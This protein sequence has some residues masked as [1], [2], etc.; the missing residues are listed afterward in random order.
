MGIVYLGRDP[1]IGRLV[2]LKTIL[3]IGEDETEQR[4]FGERFL[5]EAQAAGILSHPNIVTIHDVGEDPSSQTAFI[6]MEYVEGKNLKQLLQ[7]K[8]AYTWE[9]VA[10]IIGQVAEA[11]D[12]AHRRGIVHRDVKPANIIITPEGGV[13]ITDFGIAKIEHSNLTTEGQFLGTPNY[14]SPEQVTG[15]AVDGRTDLFSLGVVLYELLTR[16][17]PFTADN[18]TS[19]SFKIVHEPFVPPETYAAMVPPEF[20]PMLQKV[21]SKDPAERY[22]RGNDLALALYE[23]KAREEERQM[24]RDLGNMVAEAENLG[25][26]GAMQGSV[27]PFPSPS[28]GLPPGRGAPIGAEG[29]MTVPIFPPAPP[30]PPVPRGPDSTAAHDASAP[31]WA[32]DEPAPEA[33]SEPVRTHGA[34]PKTPPPPVPPKASKPEEEARPTVI[35]PPSGVPGPAAQ[36]HDATGSRVGTGVRPAPPAHLPL[37]NRPTEVIMDAARLASQGAPPPRPP[38][39]APPTRPAAAPSTLPTPSKA[40]SVL[41]PSQ[42]LQLEMTETLAPLPPVPPPPRA[43]APKKK[44]GSSRF[45]LAVVGGTL[46]LAA[47]ILGALWTRKAV[48]ERNVQATEEAKAREVAERADLMAEGNRLVGAGS[49]AEA[50]AKYREIVR[51]DPSS[52]AARDAVAKTEVLL[53]D[54]EKVVSRAKEIESHLALARQADQARDDLKVIEET[55]AALF[56]EPENAE[57]KSLHEAAHAR[58]ASRGAAEQ[59]KLAEELKKKAKPTQAPLPSVAA[60]VAAPRLARETAPPVPTPATA[61]VGISFASPIPEGHVMVSLNDKFIFRKSFAFGKKSGGG[62]VD[63][64]AEVPSGRGSFKVWVIAPDR[65]IN[66]Y[67]ELPVSIPG[68]ETKTLRLDL[69]ATGN[70]TVSLR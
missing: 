70:L 32:L 39:P 61:K 7:E 29:P 54:K 15:D 52:A 62:Q 66:Q 14:M 5:R 11:L 44:E 19:I 43:E 35:L 1:V 68:G 57:G 60:P 38:A 6:A 9:R 3:A 55:E 28:D 2:A 48:N 20:S 40:S 46:L 30:V 36:R 50:L 23:F 63:G 33:K 65:S 37:E 17:K 22:Q 26:I 12:Y 53:A 64:S 47:V 49:F 51:R 69:D 21:L 24:L 10:E 16:K 34:E 8:T 31:D 13:K 41:P 59:K 67:K 18:L 27:Q 56:L 42:A 58:I 4:E 25:G 45:V